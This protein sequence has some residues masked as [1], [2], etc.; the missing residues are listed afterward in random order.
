[1]KQKKNNL[2]SKIAAGVVF[3]WIGINIVSGIFR[4]IS[5]RLTDG[6]A[7]FN[8]AAAKI[9]ENNKDLRDIIYKTMSCDASCVHLSKNDMGDKWP[10]TVEDGE[11]R[12]INGVGN[13][14]E[15]FFTTNG[16]HYSINEAAKADDY[17]EHIEEIRRATPVLSFL[18]FI[19]T[20][21][22]LRPIEERGAELCR[23]V[24]AT[25]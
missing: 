2:V 12:C 1:M 24:S 15:V 4:S 19:N 25:S 8:A 22:S 14:K 6:G 11:L 20:E 5:L 17:F 18:P 21:V 13:G 3:G 16:S 9:R 7:D 23:A 10:F